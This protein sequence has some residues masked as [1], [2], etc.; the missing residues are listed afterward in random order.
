MLTTML[1]FNHHFLHWRADREIGKKT[2]VV[3]WGR[4]GASSIQA[5][6]D[7]CLCPFDRK[8][9]VPC[10]ARLWSCRDY[11]RYP[12]VQGLQITGQS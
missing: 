7:P 9:G 3:M 11:F 12:H 2:L 8:C 1:L 6:D 10:I 4:A 5:D